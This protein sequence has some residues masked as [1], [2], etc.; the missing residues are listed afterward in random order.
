[1]PEGDTVWLAGKRMH[2]ALASKVLIRSDFR[3]PQLATTDLSGRT[4]LEVVPRGKHLLTRLEGGLT[5]HTHFRMDGTWHLYAPGARWTG[6]ADWQVRVVLSVPDVDAVGFRLPVVELLPTER[7]DEAVG[8][9]GP[10]VLGPDW[11]EELAL[12]NL[13]REPDR[14]VGMALLDQRVLAGLGNL[15]RTEVLFLR[16]LTPWTRVGDV[17]DLPALV[18]SG[19]RLMMANRAHWEQTTTGSL[20]ARRGPLGL[21]ADRP[22]VPPVRHADRVGGAGRGAV[23]APDVLVPALPARP[24]AGPRGSTPA[25]RAA[26]R[27][28]VVPPL[29]RLRPR[30]T[31]DR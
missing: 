19:R 25:P 16:G 30:A 15:Y 24:G 6:G 21:R 18:R 17:E 13:R 4:V 3:V 1:M 7:E 11:D 22:A 27:T 2:E 5:L 23:P 9:L 14:E 28:D 26:D 31:V 8:H 10:D 29:D 12:A 20:R